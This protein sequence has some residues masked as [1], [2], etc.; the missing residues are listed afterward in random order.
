MK[1]SEL[2]KESSQK[3]KPTRT[4]EIDPE[5][6]DTLV[7]RVKKKAQSGEQETYYNPETGRYGVRPKKSVK[8][9]ATAGGTSAGSIASIA[10][11]HISPGSARGKKSY[12]GSPGKSGT[13][14]PP[15]PRAKKQSPTDNALDMKGTSIFGGPLKR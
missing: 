13:S 10:N 8:E 1:I 2:F 11:P 7:S 6:F 15:Q 5:D 4:K 9:N 12:T 3:P 14:A